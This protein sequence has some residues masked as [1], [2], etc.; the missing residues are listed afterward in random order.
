MHS[1]SVLVTATLRRITA[2]FGADIDGRAMFVESVGIVSRL[3]VRAI[4]ALPLINCAVADASEYSLA[5]AYVDNSPTGDME[6]HAECAT[7]ASGSL[8][9][10]EDHLAR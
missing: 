9:I 2:C 7:R 8:R 5:C 1:N 6:S 4:S 10:S 3:M